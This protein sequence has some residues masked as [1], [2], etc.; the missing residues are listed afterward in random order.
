EMAATYDV[1]RADLDKI[2]HENA[3]R[4]YRF[5]PFAHRAKGDC[6]VGALRA[7]VTD[8]DVATRS[9]DQ[10]RFE[11]PALPSLGEL[12]ARATA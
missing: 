5:D 3:M 4:W 9:M 6:T 1:P 11:R 12:A 8:H 7:E 2:T 10:G